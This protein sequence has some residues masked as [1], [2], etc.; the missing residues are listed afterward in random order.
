MGFFLCVKFVIGGV[1]Y[2]LW[3]F[4]MIFL[5]VLSALILEHYLSWNRRDRLSAPFD[6]WSQ[7]LR[8]VLDSGAERHGMLAWWLAMTP[9]VILGVAIHELSMRLS[10]AGLAWLIDTLI[11]GAVID[12]KTV[13][14]RLG[15]IAEDLEAERLNEAQGAIE[16]WEGSPLPGEFDLPGL[17]SRAIQLALLHAHTRVLAP[18]LWYVILPGASGPLLYVGALAL[19][20]RWT[21]VSGDNSQFYVFAQRAMQFLDWLPA[22]LSALSYAVVGNFEESLFCWKTQTKQATQDGRRIVLAAGAGALGL[23]FEPA[24]SLPYGVS[25]GELG[26]GDFPG[27]DHLENAE[28][29]L[30]RTLVFAVVMLGLLTLASL[31]G[32]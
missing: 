21:A 16:N 3:F 24:P 9:L 23:R 28:G 20:R 32:I 29:L 2:D 6:R 22:R 15:E 14:D 8:S 13:S 31:F 18:I 11:L 10:G 4:R 12:F 26:T 19:K 25:N 27:A 1:A 5:S 30:A 7:M 17:A